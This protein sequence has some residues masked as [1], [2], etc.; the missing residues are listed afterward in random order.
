MSTFSGLGTAL[1]SLIAQRQALE[2][3]GQNIANA[4][5]V[6][7]TRQRAAL[8]SLPAA[9]LPSMFS[10]TNGP[11]YGTAVTDIARLNDVFLDAQVRTTTASSSYLG[12][13]AAAS[14]LLETNIGEP[15]AT[16]LA[17][18]LTDL[19]AAFQDVANTPNKESSR[20]VLLETAA[21][22]GDRIATLYTAAG[23]QWTQA[24]TQTASL[25]E[26]ANT[27]AANIAD[28]NK[29]ILAV[30]NS[31]SSAN[32]LKDQLDL[33]VTELSGLVGATTRTQENGQIDV[34][35]GGNMMVDGSKARSL[36]VTG[37]AGFSD[38][39]GGAD[40]QV[41]WAADTSRSAGLEGGQVA[42]LLSVLAP[43]A[44][45]GTG[46]MLTEAA[47]SYD[48]LATQLA[49]QVNAL[50][51]QALTTAG[52]PGGDF[53]AFE[54]GRPAALGLTVAFD[55]PALVAVAAPGA[56]ALD[57][58]FA[59]KIGQLGAAVDGP[60]AAWSA[61]VVQLGVSTGSAVSR[62]TAA[63][64]TRA[65]A[66]AQQVAQTSVDTDEETV[67]M[68]AYQ[69]AYEGAARVMSAI[70]EMLDTLINRTGIVGR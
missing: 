1:S 7:Y 37:A 3:T 64:A 20:A 61:F 34:L 9:Q 59:D 11:G 23:T 47:A 68:L 51:G 45:G 35:V 49:T 21:A 43:P 26:K 40:V 39:T 15:A 57:G 62:A 10:T 55:D 33:L 67:N 58:S 46:G 41:V 66:A 24:R 60:D 19:W 27:A 38:A 69:R 18:Q 25:V 29:R 52:A 42:G 36:A 70:D 53:F 16:G 12:A 6:G 30:E 22:V 5:T 54:A 63:E 48:K 4:N 56:G 28:L 32:E 13:R 31:G 8:S 50:H 44:A 17:T 14:K 2:V 65:S